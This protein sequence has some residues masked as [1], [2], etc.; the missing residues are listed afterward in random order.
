MNPS[1]VLGALVADEI[2]GTVEAAGTTGAV[3]MG[4]KSTVD[5]ML[6]MLKFTGGNRD[7]RPDSADIVGSSS[8]NL[9]T[10]GID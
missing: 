6:D 5:D 3:W 10:V 8:F 7:A 4:T 2:V 9:L 1:V